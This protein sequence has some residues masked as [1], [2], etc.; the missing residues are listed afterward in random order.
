MGNPKLSRRKGRRMLHVWP[1]LLIASL[2]W[3]ANSISIDD[4][5]KLSFEGQEKAI[6]QA[7]PEMKGKLYRIFSHQ[8]LAMK[9]GGEEGFKRHQVDRSI[10]ARGF[11]YLGLF[12]IMQTDLHAQ[13]WGL[14]SDE[15][16]RAGMPREKQVL[17]DKELTEEHDAIQKRYEDVIHPLLVA[18]SPSPQALQLAKKAKDYGDELRD[19]YG[20]NETVTP[21]KPRITDKEMNAVDEYADHLLDELKS[22]PQLTPAQVE[23]EIEAL[24][25]EPLQR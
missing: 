2:A 4:F 15:N 22:L 24:P 13:H 25:D 9:Y 20:L 12:F 19:R 10:E 17:I 11:G 16:E 8:L 5:K 23:T 1:F 3:G 6:E 14:V 18:L 21:P 7:P